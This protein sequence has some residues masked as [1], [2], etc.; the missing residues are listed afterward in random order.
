MSVIKKNAK[1]SVDETV[2]VKFGVGILNLRTK[3][4]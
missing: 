3:E 1:T 2:D 4:Y